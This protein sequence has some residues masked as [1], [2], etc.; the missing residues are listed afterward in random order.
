[1]KYYPTLL[2]DYIKELYTTIGIYTPEQLDLQGIAKEMNIRVIYWDEPSQALRSRG[3]LYIALNK[4]LNLPQQW[5]DFSH[6]LCHI[7]RH[8]GDQSFLPPAFKY[9]QE[10]QATNFA[11]NFCVP[12]FMLE[13]MTFPWRKQEVIAVI[14]DT[15]NVELDFAAFRLEKWLRKKEEIYFFDHVITRENSYLH[16]R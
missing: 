10:W 5:Q 13:K 12:T 15:F 1:M 14:A 9:L 8:V 11:L 4:Y 2:E 6:E 7:L 3:R 16:R